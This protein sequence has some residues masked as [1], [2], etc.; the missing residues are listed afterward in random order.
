MSATELPLFFGNG[1]QE[2][3]GVLHS[4]ADTA[5]LA[6]VMCHP[7]GEEKLWAHRVYVSLAREL[8]RRGH[9]VLRF[10]YRGNGDS[11]GTF[12][13]TSMAS[14]LA[15]IDTAIDVLKERAGTDVVGLF[16]LRFG[17]TE[18]VLAAERR[19]DVSTV[20]LW[21]PV[22][23]GSRYMQELLRI[24]LSTQLAVFG[25]V[26]K[27]R[28]ALVAM[29]HDGQT[30][31]VDGYDM[32][33]PFYTEAC[34]VNLAAQPRTFTGRTLIVQLDR[35]ATPTPAREFVALR[36]RSALAQLQVVQC[37]PFW[38]E[39]QTFYGAA[40]SAAAVTFAWLGEQ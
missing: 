32:A 7:F 17:A 20:V 31:N 22:V 30:V 39:I 5:Q 21:Q 4:P 8:A 26:T 37:E 36:D 18:A 19:A 35:S 25:A 27:D 14:N 23:D 16:G 11:G 29:M 2:L 3:F 10:D 38:K 15:D 24:N 40:A 33:I 6:F 12:S 9:P 1:T 13:G 28:E 34:A